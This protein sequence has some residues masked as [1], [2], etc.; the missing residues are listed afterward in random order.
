[1]FF[2]SSPD[3]KSHVIY[4]QHMMLVFYKRLIFQYSS[5][6]AP[7][8]LKPKFSLPSV[9]TLVPIDD[10]AWSSGTT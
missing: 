1:M 7:T 6:E 8:G 5:Q 2:I 9:V 4:L 3:P 10:Q